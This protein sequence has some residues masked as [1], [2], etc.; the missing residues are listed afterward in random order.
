LADRRF[1]PEIRSSRERGVLEDRQVVAA[2]GTGVLGAVREVGPEVE[3]VALPQKVGLLGEPAP[4][5]QEYR[6]TVWGSA[7]L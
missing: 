4:G 5:D 6:A 2:I 7:S 1:D 3:R